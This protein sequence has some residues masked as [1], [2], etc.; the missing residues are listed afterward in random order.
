M[1]TGLGGRRGLLRKPAECVPPPKPPI[2]LPTCVCSVDVAGWPPP[3]YIRALV[4]GCS[5]L[6][7][8][9]AT[10]IVSVV[11]LPVLGWTKGTDAYNC[12]TGGLWYSTAAVPGTF[13]RVLATILF[14]DGTTCGP[15]GTIVYSP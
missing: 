7:L 1:G 3:Y 8:P 4:H 13:Y 12:G 2:I 9:D 6:S 11:S 5:L 10:L 15:Q 14:P